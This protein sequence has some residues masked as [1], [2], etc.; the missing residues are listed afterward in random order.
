MDHELVQFRAA[1]ARENRGRRHVRRRYSRALQEQAVRYWAT[2]HRAGDGL[3]TVAT[4]LGVAPWSL[5][6][7]VQQVKARARF[8]PVHVAVPAPTPATSRITVV[9]TA[10]GA[11]VEGLDVDTAARLLGLRQ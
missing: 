1:A 11:R 6:R 7:W 8:Q 10:A 2:R 5:R 4:A 9:V 3:A